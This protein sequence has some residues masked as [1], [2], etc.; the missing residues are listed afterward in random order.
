M[1]D[2]GACN[3]LTACTLIDEIKILPFNFSNSEESDKLK[4]FAKEL[5]GLEHQTR[6]LK[7]VLVEKYLVSENVLMELE[8]LATY[9]NFLYNEIYGLIL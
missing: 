2:T 4:K 6:A 7:I 9:C 3:F 1:C 5:L 8:M